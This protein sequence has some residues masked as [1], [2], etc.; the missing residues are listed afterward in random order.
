MLTHNRCLAEQI[1]CYNVENVVNDGVDVCFLKMENPI[2]PKP[3][4]RRKIVKKRHCASQSSKVPQGTIVR[5]TQC[6]RS[7]RKKINVPSA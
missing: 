1:K 5:E 6:W 2:I 4:R 3:T 7:L